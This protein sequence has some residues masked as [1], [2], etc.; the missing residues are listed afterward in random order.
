MMQTKISHVPSITSNYRRAPY[1]PH[2]SEWL[3]ESSKQSLVL[4]L[5]FEKLEEKLYNRGGKSN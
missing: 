5:K 3:F 2:A 4:T 1:S